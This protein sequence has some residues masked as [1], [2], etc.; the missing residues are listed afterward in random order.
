M[1]WLVILK[2]SLLN[3]WDSEK[4][5]S[6]VNDVKVSVHCICFILVVHTKQI[7]GQFHAASFVTYSKVPVM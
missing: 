7:L 1:N 5:V 3:C 6:F 4:V 2:N